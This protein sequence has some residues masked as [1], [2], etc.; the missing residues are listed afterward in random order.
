LAAW[1]ARGDRAAP[2]AGEIPWTLLESIDRLE[3]C[4]G[5][6]PEPISRLTAFR[7]AYRTLLE[8]AQGVSL[9]EL[10]R[11]ILDRTR[12]WPEIEALGEAARL[13]ARLNLY[14]FLDL[15]EEWS[16]LEGAPSLDAFL[17]YL[18]LL[19]EEQGSDQLDT[20]RVSREDAVALLTVHRAKGLEWPVVVLPALCRGT[21]PS[22]AHVYPDPITRAQF[23]PESL[24]LDAGHR[25]P[26]PA[27]H[28]ERRAVLRA[29]HDDQEWRTAYVAVARAQHTLI[30]SGAFWYTERSTRQPSELFEAAAAI[31]GA[32]R[33]VETD[34]PGD[35]PDTLRFEPNEGD[36]PDPVF[37][38]G[39]LEALRAAVEDPGW[40]AIFSAG[41]IGEE[42]FAEAA[43]QLRLELEGLP[44]PTPSPRAEDVFRTSVTGLVTFATCPQRFH[45]SEVDRL[46]RRPSP[47]MRHGIEVHRRIELHNRG[48]VPLDEADPDLYDLEP[49]EAAGPG[50]FETFAASRFAAEQP[51]LVEAP[52]ELLV[53][54]CRVA[55]R[56]DAVYEPEPGLWEVVDFKSGRRSDH[57]ARRVQLE[58][59]A[60]AAS[61]AGF[62]PGPPERIRVAF[63][64]LGD[65]LEVVAEEVDAAWLAEARR[66][67]EE[68]IAA[69]AAG[70]S[71]PTPSEA[72]RSCDFYRFCE[73]GRVWLA[74]HGAEG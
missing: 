5:L 69:A 61:E 55:G 25:P 48:A 22:G 3:E 20:A 8:A 39:W 36:A 41:S 10:C 12:A 38:A 11:Q 62:T 4:P 32:E 19:G 74:A 23:I 14:R 49:G 26:L 59:Y 1:A 29:E 67:I 64:Y 31:P 35:S 47:A 16:P 44:R 15:A 54:G 42:A 13:S 17:D 40:P 45:W 66:H 18:D 34:E 72:C 9:V 6:D 50:A 27:D 28:R 7:K 60:V 37:P 57:P 30:A 56:V 24:R 51:I 46:P 43:G 70:S 71:E 53:A 2:Q 68:L 52:F 73:P 63:A 21:F 65:G 33:V 58:A